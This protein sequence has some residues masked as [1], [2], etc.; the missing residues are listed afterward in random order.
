MLSARLQWGWANLLPSDSWALH[1]EAD[2]YLISGLPG[3][4]L[5]TV[6]DCLCD[7][8]N[9]EFFWWFRTLYIPISDGNLCFVSRATFVPL[10]WLCSLH[11]KLKQVGKVRRKPPYFWGLYIPSG[12]S[13][14]Q[15]EAL[16]DRG[17]QTKR[18]CC[19]RWAGNS[20]SNC[21]DWGWTGLMKTLHDRPDKKVTK[22]NVLWAISHQ[23]FLEQDSGFYIE[24]SGV[25][26]G[27]LKVTRGE[28]S[29]ISKF[30][31][32]TQGL[33][34]RHLL[35]SEWSVTSPEMS[36]Q[37]LRFR[38]HLQILYI[39]AFVRLYSYGGKLWLTGDL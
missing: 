27:E 4:F 32:S 3:L 34:L 15:M 22:V 10:C 20:N 25:L 35:L 13:S 31:L 29:I 11:M 33:G 36:E 7:M 1:R 23:T 19:I 39:F 26:I 16:L 5:F 14:V 18:A 12:R 21:W 38:T 2:R 24:A 17:S 8:M 30:K 28:N 9:F 6:S 37:S